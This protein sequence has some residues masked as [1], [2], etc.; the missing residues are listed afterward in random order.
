MDG[1]LI[2]LPLLVL[3]CWGGL[4]QADSIRLRRSTVVPANADGLA[5]KVVADLVGPAALAAGEVIIKS[6]D[7]RQADGGTVVTL[8]EIREAL[9]AQGINLGRLAI[10]GDRCQIYVGATETAEAAA[11]QAAVRTESQDAQRPFDSQPGAWASTLVDEGNLRGQIARVI[12]NDVQQRAAKTIRLE[13]SDRDREEL[14]LTTAA[15]DFEII[16]QATSSSA[17]LPMQVKV[18]QGE[19]FIRSFRVIVKL[20]LEQDVFVAQRYLSRGETVRPGDFLVETQLLQPNAVGVFPTTEPV[21]GKETRGRLV[22]GAVL[23]LGDALAPVSV[24][25]NAEIK[26]IIKRGD[27]TISMLG[28][29]LEAGRTGEIIRVRSL[30][31]KTEMRARIEDSGHLAVVTD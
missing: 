18:F 3:L 25:K 31:N 21:I 14:R 2:C 29:A 9:Q 7:E 13:F 15:H 6:A 8:K 11:N 26:L 16:P 20:W 17:V 24:R 5:L 4:V 22:K 19:R 10:S 12:A 23:R 27:F 30:K 28:R 1:L